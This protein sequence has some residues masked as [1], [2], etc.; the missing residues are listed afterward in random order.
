MP[1]P[2][3]IC[4]KCQAVAAPDAPICRNC[5]HGFSTQFTPP[6][7]YS[8]PSHAVPLPK[9]R[10]TA[11]YL[12]TCLLPAVLF[13]LFL[14]AAAFQG[15][16]NNAVTA[17]PPTDVVLDQS[18]TSSLFLQMPEQQMLQLFGKPGRAP[19]PTDDGGHLWVYDLKQ[20]GCL[21]VRFG[22]NGTD[23]ILI[24]AMTIN[25]PVN[26]KIRHY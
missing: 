10:T 4:P 5:G 12:L 3:K 2:Q 18:D 20:G 21:A 11:F 1:S 25:S 22:W 8:G 7:P 6:L 13:V 15:A 26:W 17:S 14:A 19:I 16:R 24:D 23:Y 9:H